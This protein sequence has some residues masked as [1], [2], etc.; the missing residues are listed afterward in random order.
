M[1]QMTGGEA[2]VAGLMDHGIDT[3]FGLPGAQTYGLFDALHRTQ[4]AI[5]IVGAR[6]EQTCAYM[7]FGYARATGRPSAF[8]VV[9]GPGM[10]NASAGLL[11]ALACNEPVLLLTGQVPTSF[12]GSGRGHLHEMPDQLATMRGFVK[13]AE[14]VNSPARARQG[15]AQ[16]FQQMLSGRRGP[17]AL[18]MPW[19][20]FTQTGE[21]QNDAP[22]P[23]LPPPSVDPDRIAEAAKLIGASKH[24]MIFVGAGAFDAADAIL[25]LAE[26]ID[27][28]VIG[29]RSGRGIVSN[30][31]E[32][33]LTIAGA[34]NLWPRTDL[35]IGIGT[36]LEAPSWRWSW[37]PPGLRTIR[38][39]ID[40]AEMKRLVPD[41]A[42]VGDAAPATA[43]LV[44]AVRRHGFRKEQ[45]RRQA[46]R[47]ASC[48]A[49]EQIQ[50]IQPQISYLKI[51]RD[52]LPRDGFVTD[53][54][55]QVGFASWYGFPVYEPRTYVTSGY[56][57]TLGSGF[58]TALG[59]KIAH[60]EKPVV[61]I[62]GDGGFMFAAQELATAAQYG[63]GVVTLVFNNGGFGNVRRDQMEQFGGRTLVAE[64]QNPDFVK[65]TESF[66]LPA[67]SVDTP[68]DFRRALERALTEGGPHL[69]EIRVAPGAET[70]PWRFI[71]PPPPQS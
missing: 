12:L 22:L 61:A 18:E 15:V 32:L 58:P 3:V 1:S 64:L 35:M 26:E 28:P 39:D 66:G 67:T 29:F 8:S 51:L 52:V 30:D 34:Y 46:I 53:E 56:M 21:V 48:L 10:L 47:D 19:D 49:E 57:G 31:H 71:H 6:H 44:E 14:H 38:I 69:I 20:I 24:P 55:S 60:P 42:I 50:A 7:A 37:Q 25:A 63:I 59:I 4:S 17:A 62:T 43:S 54:L 68:Q 2:L 23:L 5:K 36:R 70:N 27:A 65:F 33:G 40:P 11:T 13:W 9:P 45:G 16:A 41:V